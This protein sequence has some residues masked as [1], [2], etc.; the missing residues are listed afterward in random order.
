MTKRATY[1]G[2]SYA[3]FNDSLVHESTCVQE[4]VGVPPDDDV[5]VGHVLG[6]LQV[7]LEARVAQR[8][9]DVHS[10]P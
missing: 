6:D 7:L 10:L 9:Q 8:D 4:G 1:Q 5:D 2:A 3:F